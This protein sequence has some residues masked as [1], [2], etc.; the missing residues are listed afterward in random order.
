MPV[1]SSRYRYLL[2]V[3][4]TDV[5]MLNILR[6]VISIWHLLETDVRLVG[7]TGPFEGRLEVFH[8]G[9]WGTVC[10]SAFDAS[11]AVVI[12]KMLGYQQRFVS[13]L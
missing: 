3:S 5:S 9:E 1:L 2:Y 7:G 12:C 6:H 11:D 8:N 4:Y 10:D 13:C